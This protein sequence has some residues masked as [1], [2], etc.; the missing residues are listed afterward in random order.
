M[1]EKGGELLNGGW[2][3]GRKWDVALVWL[4]WGRDLDGG[5]GKN[6]LISPSWLASTCSAKA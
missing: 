6:A 2:G 4:G 1:T 3:G 5:G